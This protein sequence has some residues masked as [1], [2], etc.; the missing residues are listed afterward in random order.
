M[1]R[2]DGAAH[3]RAPAGGDAPGIPEFDAETDSWPDAPPL[4][5]DDAAADARYDDG[6]DRLG[7]DLVE[8]DDPEDPGADE[9][10]RP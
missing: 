6:F 2:H 8:D 5:D 4:E 7:L 9:L 3:R 1:A 10:A